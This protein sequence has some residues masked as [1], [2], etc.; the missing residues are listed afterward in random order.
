MQPVDILGQIG[1]Q[2]PRWHLHAACRDADPSIFFVNA[3]HSIA[4]ALEYCTACPVRQECLDYALRNRLTTGIF[5]GLTYTGRKLHARRLDGT[6]P[7]GKPIGKLRRPT[8]GLQTRR[9]PR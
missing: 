5:G 7:V 9:N 4:E 2:L 8:F 1:T 6:E 3:G